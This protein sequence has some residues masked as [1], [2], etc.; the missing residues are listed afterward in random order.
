MPVSL[1]DVLAEVYRNLREK[2]IKPCHPFYVEIWEHSDH[3]PVER[4]RKHIIW[5]SI[6]S[7]QLF[8]GFSGSGKTTQLRRLQ[9]DLEG[10]EPIEIE[11]TSGRHRWRL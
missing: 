2:P 10:R 1:D 6:E 11:G 3:D 5:T 9:Q 4:L 7:F 8:S